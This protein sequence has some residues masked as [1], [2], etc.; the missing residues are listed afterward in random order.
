M[1][2][3]V[4]FRTKMGSGPSA[5]AKARKEGADAIQNSLLP[6]SLMPHPQGGERVGPAHRPATL[7]GGLQEQRLRRTLLGFWAA[8]L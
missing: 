2:T 7:A 1:K 4:K 6:M 5:A 8:S 3:N